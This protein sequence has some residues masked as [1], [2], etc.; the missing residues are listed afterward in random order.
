[1]EQNTTKGRCRRANA[2]PP[3][4]RA[5]KRD[6][7]ANLGPR[8]GRRQDAHNSELRGGRRETGMFSQLRGGHRGG[9]SPR[10]GGFRQR[11]HGFSQLH[12]PG[13]DPGRSGGLIGAT[14]ITERAK[15]QK[16]I[17]SENRALPPI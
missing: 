9:S 4:H 7:G 1:M 15:V 10:D 6:D 11:V 16:M 13:R 12:I 17:F 8:V 3:K 5:G 2:Q 14:E